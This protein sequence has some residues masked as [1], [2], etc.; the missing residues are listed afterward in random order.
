MLYFK[1]I[2]IIAVNQ[3]S[4]GIILEFFKVEDFGIHAF[5]GFLEGSFSNFN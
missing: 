4:D 5:L 1:V 2:I 3:R